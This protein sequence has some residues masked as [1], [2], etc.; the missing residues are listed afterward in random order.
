MTDTTLQTQRKK[1]LIIDDEK[2]LLF[3]LKAIMTRAGFEVIDTSEGNEGARLAREQLPDLVICDVMMPPPNGF[4]LKKILASDHLTALIPFIFL[5]ARSSEVDKIAGLSQGADDYITKPFNVDLL[6]ARVQAI[7]RRNELGRQSGLQEMEATLEKVRG[8]IA[9][10]MAHEMRAP[11]GTIMANL[12]QAIREKSNGNLNDLDWYLGKSMNS[13]QRLEALTSNLL[14]LNDIDQKRVKCTRRP[15]DLK[16]RFIEPIQKTLELYR[17]KKLDV[18]ISIEPGTLIHAAE[19][20][21]AL[22]VTHL[23]DNAFK[24]SSEGG[25]VW[26]KLGKNGSGGC[27]LSIENAGPQ[28]ALK[29]REKVFERYFQA[30]PSE[31][32]PNNGLGV[33]LTITRAVVEACGGNVSI[34][35]SDMG[36]KVLLVYPPGPADPAP[37]LNAQ[38]VN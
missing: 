27:T 25:K 33:G 26:I 29:L 12:E 23:A 35:D 18:Q 32:R 36:C 38:P 14:L 31:E 5:T 9:V 37:E 20:E 19:N 3:G 6:L 21:F 15:V 34:V 28:I 10:N 30:Q 22:A 8:S 16:A 24:F 4:Q 11:I 1:I 13:V 2:K 7:L 17:D